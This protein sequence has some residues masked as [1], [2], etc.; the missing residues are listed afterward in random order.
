MHSC[1]TFIER[2]A[3]VR[4]EFAKI[5]PLVDG[6]GRAS[7]LLMNLELMKAGFP[8]TVV[9]VE[10]RLAYYEALDTTHC[11]G[12]YRNFIELVADSVEQSYKPC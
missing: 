2:A 7:R 11:S 3:Y 10:Q 12:D 5:H 8:A 1:Y 4:G 6:N 9:T